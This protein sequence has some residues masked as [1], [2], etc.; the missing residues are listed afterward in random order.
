M[1]PGV[2]A[3]VDRRDGQ[4]S[5]HRH[6][7][8]RGPAAGGDGPA[9]QH[10]RGRRPYRRRLPALAG[11]RLAGRSV[12]GPAARQAADDRLRRRLRAAVREPARRRMGQDARHGPGRGGRVAGRGRQCPVRDRI[13]GLLARIGLR[14]RAGGR[15]HQAAGQRVGGRDRRPRCGGPGRRG[16]GR[17]HRAAVQ[18]GQFPGLGRVPAAHQDRR[19]PARSRRTRHDGAGGHL[20]GR[21]VHRRR[22]LPAGAH[23]LRDDRQPRL[24]RQ[25]GA[26]GR[27]PGPGGRVRLGCRRAAAGQRR[28]G[29]SAR[30]RAHQAA[31]PMAGHGPCH[32]AERADRRAVQPADPA[33]RN[34]P[35][36]RVLRGGGGRGVGR[37][38]GRQHRGP[39]LPAGLL[40]RADARAD[41]RVHAFPAVRHD[42]ARRAARRRPRHRPGHQERAVD[43]P[44]PVRPVRDVPAHPG[45]RGATGPARGPMW[46]WGPRGPSGFSARVPRWWWWW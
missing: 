26:A 19:G 1:A 41:H 14:G 45:H 9:R 30:C 28:G 34:R 29:G 39:E 3:A 20:P 23:R 25:H 27:L 24:Q 38:G 44:G 15:Q 11:D 35:A 12:G 42:P 16:R 5:R 22:R 4:R 33:R 8:R 6:G 46:P 36:G 43:R 21:A 13:S 7:R 32:A 17:C 31:D 10:L 40:S 18:R 37:D 2:P